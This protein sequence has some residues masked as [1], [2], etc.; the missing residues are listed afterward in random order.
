MRGRRAPILGTVTMDQLMIVVDDHVDVGDE[1]VLIGTDGGEE[2]TANEVGDRLDTI[3]YEV[4][5]AIGPRVRRVHI[6]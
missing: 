1:V 4:L 2:I 5:T 3:G 6:G